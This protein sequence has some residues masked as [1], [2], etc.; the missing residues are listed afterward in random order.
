MNLIDSHAHLDPVFF[1]RGLDVV[2][3]ECRRELEAVVTIGSGGGP[4]SPRDAVALAARHDFIY[5]TVGLHPHDARRWSDELGREIATLAGEPKVVAIGECG[6]DY[7]YDKSPRD[8]QQHAF[9]DQLRLARELSLPVVLHIRDAWPDAL[10]ILEEESA[11]EI[12]GVVHCFT[13]NGDNAARV[14][15]MGFF[16]G[17]TGIAT[18]QH[19]KELRRVLATVPLDRL[20]VETDSPFLTPQAVRRERPNRPALVKYVAEALAAMQNHSFEEIASVTTRNARRLF[21]L[22]P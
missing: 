5:A 4:G 2:I 10:A 17:V 9:R 3:D 19:A 12:G 22:S 14:L 1:E 7:F 8:T 13:G 6:L 20:V 18:Y 15:D 11:H 16:L 21:R